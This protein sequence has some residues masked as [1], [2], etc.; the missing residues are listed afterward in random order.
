MTMMGRTTW[1]GAVGSTTRMAG[2]AVIAGVAELSVPGAGAGIRLEVV[3]VAV[4]I[5]TR[6]TGFRT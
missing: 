1:T 3:P 5:T 2:R 6:G 4:A